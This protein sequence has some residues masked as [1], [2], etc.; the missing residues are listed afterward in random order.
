MVPEYTDAAGLTVEGSLSS[1]V[2]RIVNGTGGDGRVKVS[3]TLRA[4]GKVPAT[5]TEARALTASS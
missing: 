3:C 4:L 1:V 2:Y 5:G